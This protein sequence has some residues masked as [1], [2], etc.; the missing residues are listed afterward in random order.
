MKAWAHPDPN[1]TA[2]FYHKILAFLRNFSELLQN[3][4]IYFQSG[5]PQPNLVL[6]IELRYA[7][8]TNIYFLISTFKT[9]RFGSFFQTYLKH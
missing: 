1:F 3:M 8:A 5:T 9:Q 6:T 2:R 7:C 4:D